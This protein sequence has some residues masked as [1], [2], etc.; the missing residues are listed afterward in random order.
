MMKGIINKKVSILY[1]ITI[2]L[3]EINFFGEVMIFIT[4]I[5][6]LIYF[7]YILSLSFGLLLFTHIFDILWYNVFDYDT[8]T[9]YAYQIYVFYK[10][11]NNC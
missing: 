6:I 9:I 3:E 7:V 2:D 4:L 10:L 1:C 5:Y 8:K 11:E